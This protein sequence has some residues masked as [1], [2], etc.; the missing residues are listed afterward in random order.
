MGFLL[1]FGVLDW[2]GSG[3]HSVHLKGIL[4]FPFRNVVAYLVETCGARD[5]IGAVDE[6]KETVLDFADA[7][8]RLETLQPRLNA[9]RGFL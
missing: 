5:R 6:N 9:A 4:L 8:K 7:R 2:L 3:A 1:R